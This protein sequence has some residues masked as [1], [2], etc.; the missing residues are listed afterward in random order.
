MGWLM[1]TVWFRGQ[2][3]IALT[4]PAWAALNDLQLQQLSESVA[5]DQQLL[6]TKGQPLG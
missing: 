3:L 4:G 1:R 5:G 6:K 2:S